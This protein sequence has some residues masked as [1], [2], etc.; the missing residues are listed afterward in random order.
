MQSSK[1]L[2]FVASFP[3]FSQLTA[4]D[5]M[6][7]VFVSSM[8]T[9]SMIWVLYD[10]WRVSIGPISDLIPS[11]GMGHPVTHAVVDVVGG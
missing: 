7:T 8:A 9:A 11:E 5:S 6:W 4:K 2:F 10:A 3:M 1:A